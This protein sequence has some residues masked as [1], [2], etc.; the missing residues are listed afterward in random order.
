MTVPAETVAEVMAVARGW[1]ESW[2]A[3]GGW[4]DTPDVHRFD[5]LPSA[6]VVRAGQEVC[7]FWSRSIDKVLDGLYAAGPGFGADRLIVVSDAYGATEK[8][9]RERGVDKIR[10]GMLEKLFERGRT[11]L[12]TE[13]IIATWADKEGGCWVTQAGY[14]IGDGPTVEWR[15]GPGDG[16]VGEAPRGRVP[17]VLREVL[18]Q[19]RDFL[20]ELEALRIPQD[21]DVPAEAARLA[22]DMATIRQLTIRGL[23]VKMG[24]RDPEE[25][26]A[27][28]RVFSGEGFKYFVTGPDE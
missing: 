27:Y 26:A 9:L 21:M 2:V 20:L 17:R 15:D 6:I 3:H 28:K 22:A 5:V 23:Q 24:T 14:Q 16:I 8:F 7:E 11:D 19:H 12:A 13:C 10:T 1:K 4:K 18:A 25:L